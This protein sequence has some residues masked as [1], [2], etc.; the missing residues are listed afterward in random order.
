MTPTDDITDP[1]WHD[2]FD[3]DK[4]IKHLSERLSR[5]LDAYGESMKEFS[6]CAEEKDAL[7]KELVREIEL[8]RN[9]ANH[10]L[11]LGQEGGS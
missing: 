9:Q 8:L 1:T 4:E 2:I 3:R 11:P 7:I 10:S 6:R 5:L